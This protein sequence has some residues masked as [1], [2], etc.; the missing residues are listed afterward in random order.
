MN[1][2]TSIYKNLCETMSEGPL[3]H[4]NLLGPIAFSYLKEWN[5]QRVWNDPVKPLG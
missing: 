5:T 2:E 1:T 3:A 4:H